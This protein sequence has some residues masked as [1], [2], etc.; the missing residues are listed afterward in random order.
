MYLIDSQTI[1]NALKEAHVYA[2]DEIAK[3]VSIIH[4][5]LMTLPDFEACRLVRRIEFNKGDMTP[6]NINTLVKKTAIKEFSK[7]LSDYWQM[8]SKSDVSGVVRKDVELIILR[9]KY[10]KDGNEIPRDLQLSKIGSYETLKHPKSVNVANQRKEAE[11]IKEKQERIE[12]KIQKKIQKE[13]KE[14]QAKE[15]KMQ[16][17]IQKII[18][19]AKERGFNFDEYR[20][21]PAED[22]YKI[23]IIDDPK[24]INPTIYRERSNTNDKRN[25]R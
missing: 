6:R 1:V 11:K 16:L 15:E 20:T 3:I 19:E 4:Q 25:K 17:K 13:I 10:D 22:I 2:D 7:V 9:L 24:S 5:H 12:R 23:P 21:A 18:D 8:I 14:Q